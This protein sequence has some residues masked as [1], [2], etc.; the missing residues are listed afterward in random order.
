MIGLY[1][2][3][4]I[5]YF[6]YISFLPIEQ[7]SYK[8]QHKY[9]PSGELPYFTLP[10]TL[11]FLFVFCHWPFVFSFLLD[12][13]FHDEKGDNFPIIHSQTV[14]STNV[15]TEC[16]DEILLSCLTLHIKHIFGDWLASVR[17]WV[18]KGEKNYIQ[19]EIFKSCFLN[20]QSKLLEA[21]TRELG[22]DPSTLRKAYDYL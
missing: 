19:E 8:I 14:P 10:K 5:E 1:H 15:C 22:H 20:L 3:Y 12:S 7:A 13:K 6:L 18:I 2:S 21:L 17:S 11:L 9:Q 4:C 16:D